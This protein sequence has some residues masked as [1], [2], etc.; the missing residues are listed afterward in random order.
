MNRLGHQPATEPDQTPGSIAPIGSAEVEAEKSA[1]GDSSHDSVP[2]VDEE[3]KLFA[4]AF[5]AAM[6]SMG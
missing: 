3:P 6:V 5:P 4:P 2:R 1:R